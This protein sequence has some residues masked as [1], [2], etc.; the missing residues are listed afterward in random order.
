[1]VVTASDSS[2]I[3]LPRENPKIEGLATSYA[4]GDTVVAKCISDLADPAPIL[5]WYINRTPVPLE[6]VGEATTSKPDATGLVSRSITLRLPL[7]RKLS[8]DDSIEIRCESVLPG[9]P[10]P[11]QAT[12]HTVSLRNPRDPQVINNQKLHWYSTSGGAT[13]AVRPCHLTW[14]ISVLAMRWSIARIFK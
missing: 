4:E 7:D 1:M 8:R 11:P 5:S 3:A 2:F 6:V 10:E 9:V 14:M 13:S 12:T